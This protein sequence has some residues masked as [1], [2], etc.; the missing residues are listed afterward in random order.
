MS[1]MP[2]GE[3]LRAEAERL[4][5]RLEGSG[6]RYWRSLDDLAQ[7]PEFLEFLHREFPEGASSWN[8][9]NGRRD[10]LKLMGAS[11]ALAGLGTACTRQPEEKIVPYVKMPEGI[12]P[13]RPLFYATAVVDRGYAKGVLVESHMGRPTKIE[14]NPE[15]PASLGGSDVFAQAEILNLYDPDRSQTITNMGEIRAWGAFVA[16][17]RSALEAQKGIG[18]AGLR[19]LTGCVTSPTLASQIEEILKELPKAKWHQWEPLGRDNSRAG[20]VLAFG[21]PVETHYRF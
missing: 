10:F 20:A 2:R 15:H 6:R 17:M 14:G 19:I 12:I 16:A 9:E 11:L 3:R 8:E 13:G 18:G 1:E 4:R 7:T 5:D 21:E